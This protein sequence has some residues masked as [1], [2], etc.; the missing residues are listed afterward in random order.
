MLAA[1]RILKTISVRCANARPRTPRDY[2]NFTVHNLLKAS[3]LSETIV[4]GDM[5]LD[6]GSGDGHTLREL[7]LFRKI[8]PV[9]VEITVERNPHSSTRVVCHGSALPFVD[10]AFDVTL[11]CYVLHHLPED[12]AKAFILEAVRVARKKILLLEDSMVDFCVFYRLRNLFHRLEGDWEYGSESN[13]YRT[14]GGQEMFLT[15]DQWNRLLLALPGVYGVSVESLERISRYA[16]HTLIRVD[17]APETANSGSATA[18]T[19]L[20]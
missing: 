5:V 3:R 9:G 18:T 20:M 7:M 8:R 12:Q 19:D 6:I 10:K 13:A 2:L 11:I 15:Y 14:P 16:H 4:D 17:T 1:V